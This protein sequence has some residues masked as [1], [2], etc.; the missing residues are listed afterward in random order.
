MR[1]I[2]AEDVE[3]GRQLFRADFVKA[4]EGSGCALLSIKE[5]KSL[6]PKCRKAI[7]LALNADKK[8][9]D[10]HN[11]VLAVLCAFSAATFIGVMRLCGF[12]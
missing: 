9:R 11:Y 7:P 1:A 10:Y 3:L 5:I 8:K 12:L 2:A 4:L 6:M